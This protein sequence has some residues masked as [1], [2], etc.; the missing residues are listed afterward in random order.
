M[1]F[2]VLFWYFPRSSFLTFISN[3]SYINFLIS[4]SFTKFIKQW[5]FDNTVWK[6]EP[7]LFFH[8]LTLLQI[9]F[10]QASCNR[11][12]KITSLASD[13]QASGR[14]YRA[15]KLLYIN[16]NA[17]ETVPVSVLRPSPNDLKLH[18]MKEVKM[19]LI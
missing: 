9:F 4:V 6:I 16:E 5:I 10:I 8:V 15:V 17:Q 3:L 18:C 1:G 14:A 2:Y 7:V 12:V 19:M 11:I 13:T